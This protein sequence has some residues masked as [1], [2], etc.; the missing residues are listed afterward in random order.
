[1]EEW[2]KKLEQFNIAEL[3]TYVHGV[4]KDLDAVKNG[5]KYGYNN[6]VESSVNKIKVIKRTMYRQ[7]SF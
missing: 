7:D 6:V 2:L 4:R 3:E 1:M 5:I